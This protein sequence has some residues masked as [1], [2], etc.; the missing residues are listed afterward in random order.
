MIK[1]PR[2]LLEELV[3]NWPVDE[4]GKWPK[5]EIDKNRIR[6]QFQSHITDDFDITSF[7]ARIRPQTATITEPLVTGKFAKAVIYS[8][9]PFLAVLV[10]GNDNVWRLNILEFQCVTCFGVGIDHSLGPCAT[11]GGSGWGFLGSVEFC[12][13]RIK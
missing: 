7:A 9:D 11:C 4:F 5:S 2:E 12:K 10:Q 3:T 1:Q 6:E 8:P 13:G